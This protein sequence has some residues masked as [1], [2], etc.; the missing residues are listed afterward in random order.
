MVDIEAME[1]RLE[2]LNRRNAKAIDEAKD[3]N[4]VSKLPFHLKIQAK[5]FEEQLQRV[6]STQRNA[7]KKIC[8]KEKIH[9]NDLKD[10]FALFWMEFLRGEI[11]SI[12]QY[13]KRKDFNE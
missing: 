3:L 9:K 5:G 4:R 10:E 1:E 2:E 12:N 8:E 11:K 7:F 13:L 6:E